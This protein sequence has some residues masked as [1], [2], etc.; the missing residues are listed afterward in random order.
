MTADQTPEALL[1][2]AHLAADLPVR[3]MLTRYTCDSRAKP[4]EQGIDLTAIRVQGPRKD[5]AD[6][7]AYSEGS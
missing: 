5:V 7:V 1:L 4:A 6:S 3:G 2:P